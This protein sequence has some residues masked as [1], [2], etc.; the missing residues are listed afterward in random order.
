MCINLTGIPAVESVTDADAVTTE[1]TSD[2][3]VSHA[4]PQ[5]YRAGAFNDPDV[6][7][8]IKSNSRVIFEEKRCAIHPH[9]DRLWSYTF[10]CL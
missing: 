9:H 5:Q 1:V 7:S 2:D 4:A 3:P 6:E 10:S 8:N